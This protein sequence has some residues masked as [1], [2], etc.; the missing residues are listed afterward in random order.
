MTIL[1]GIEL[2]G[3]Y[4]VVFYDKYL[5]VFDDK[6]KD[7]DKEN[8]SNN[9]NINIESEIKPNLIKN[10][11]NEFTNIQKNKIYSDNILST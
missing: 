7:N 5:M 3:T 6:G 8:L 1:K 9:D 10:N 11:I 4:K 2:K